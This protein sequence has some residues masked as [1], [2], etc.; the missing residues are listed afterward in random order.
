MFTKLVQLLRVGF[1]QA[2]SSLAAMHSYRIT[3]QRRS[4]HHTGQ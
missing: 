3:T 2:A 4:Q 1:Q